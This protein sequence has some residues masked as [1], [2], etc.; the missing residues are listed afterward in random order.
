MGG[1]GSV[2]R[3]EENIKTVVTETHK[4]KNPVEDAVTIFEEGGSSSMVRCIGFP[5][6]YTFMNDVG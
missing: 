3:S 4:I 6:K 2:C 1:T 5:T